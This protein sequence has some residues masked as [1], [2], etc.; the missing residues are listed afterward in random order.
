M[1]AFLRRG[2][3]SLILPRAQ[4]QRGLPS[5]PKCWICDRA[6]DAYGIER[7]NALEIEVWARC[8]GIPIDP[9]TGLVSGIAT[10][11]HEPKKTSVVIQKTR[12]WSYNRFQ[13]IIARQAFF[14]PPT[15]PIERE[16]RQ[17]LTAE[18][19]HSS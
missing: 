6:V 8:G 12:A 9:D 13:D 19:V 4:A 1:R 3:G 17:D 10:R 15:E 14:A 16:Y 7:E 11:K 2:E 5:W 18:G